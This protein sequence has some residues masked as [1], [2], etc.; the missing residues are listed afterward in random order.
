MS[1]LYPPP[2]EREICHYNKANTDFICRS[3]H[4][5]LWENRFSNTDANQRVYLFNETINNISSLTLHHTRQSFVTIAIPHGS[6]AKLKIL[7]QKK[8]IVKKCYLQN[9]SDIQLFRRF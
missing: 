6:I 4:E 7:S 8:N 2:Y 1:F 9:N 3:I 5:F